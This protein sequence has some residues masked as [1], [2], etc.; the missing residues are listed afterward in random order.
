[1]SM[2]ASLVWTVPAA[3]LIWWNL[4]HK[5]R[6]P[7]LLLKLGA[8]KAPGYVAGGAAL[9]ACLDLCLI[10]VES[11]GEIKEKKKTSYAFLNASSWP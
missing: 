11:E 4:H 5:K 1:M 10:S 3:L 9:S 6:N 7:Q 2:W 8:D